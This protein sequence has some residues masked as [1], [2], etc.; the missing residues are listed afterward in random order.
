MNGDWVRAA[1]TSRMSTLRLHA[2]KA[3]ARHALWFWLP[4]P[5]L[6]SAHLN[7]EHH[8]V[9]LSYFSQVLE[10]QVEHLHHCA[11][12]P[13]PYRLLVRKAGEMLSKGRLHQ[14]WLLDANNTTIA[15]AARHVFLWRRNRNTVACHWWD[16][17]WIFMDIVHWRLTT[18]VTAYNT[19]TRCGGMINFWYLES[20]HWLKSY[21]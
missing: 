20:L 18:I 17:R 15:T 19:S 13:S 2:P 5:L 1:A 7:A 9:D 14:L 4:V 11:K 12:V 8:F 6:P 3:D 16:G 21:C 10:I